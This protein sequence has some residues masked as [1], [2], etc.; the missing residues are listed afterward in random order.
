MTK[1]LSAITIASIISL[2]ASAYAQTDKEKPGP[3]GEQFKRAFT[4]AI[5]DGHVNK[6]CQDMKGTWETIEGAEEFRVCR[7]EKGFVQIGARTVM[8]LEAFK[9][10]DGGGI[11]TPRV[12][13]CA[14]RR[15]YQDRSL[16]FDSTGK[17]EI[18]APEALGGEWKD[19]TPG[20]KSDA[21]LSAVCRD[22]IQ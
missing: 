21:V 12:F 9:N 15:T 20:S 8:A 1:R 5:K 7:P 3:A 11:L 17:I 22:V 18:Y 6:V 16:S 2:A 4:K 13:D 19:V 14:R 10:R